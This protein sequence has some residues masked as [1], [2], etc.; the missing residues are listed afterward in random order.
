LATGVYTVT[1]TNANGCS[2]TA[3]TSTTINANPIAT[4]SSNIPCDGSTLNLTSGG[5]SSYNWSG[6]NGFSDTIQFPIM[7]NITPSAA[8]VYT[9]VVTNANGCSSSAQTTVTINANPIATASSNTPCEGAALNLTSGG[10]TAYSWS[11][12]NNFSNTTQ[13][14]A[15]TNVAISAGGTYTVTVTNAN[16][17][18]STAQTTATV[19]ANPTATASSNTPCVGATLNLTSGGGSGYSWSGP[20]S[21]SST[22]QNPTIANAAISA[23][24]SYTVTVTDA[25]GCSD[26]KNINV[27]IHSL[28]LITLSI[29]NN[30][31]CLTANPATL[32]GTPAGGSF[33][34]TGI[35]DSI[36]NP[37][38]AGIGTYNLI[39]YYTD[40]NSCSNSD[41]ISVSV[42][43]VPAVSLQSDPL[44]L[45]PI[46]TG[47]TV[48]ITAA[49]TNYSNYN[50]YIGS[51]SVQSGSSNTYQ[52]V[53]FL[54]G[55][56]VIVIATEDGC[57]ASDTLVLDINPLP[58][59]F[60]PNGS[61]EKNN[62][63][64][65]G[66]DLQIINR[67]GQQLYSGKDGWDGTYNGQTVSPGTY[68]YIIKLTDLN[69]NEKTIKGAVTV[70]AKK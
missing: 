50:F 30:T 10:G 14:P 63:F 37:S 15:I 23:G 28:P 13:N 11:G 69:K 21:F 20:N 58:N 19:N 31:Y 40:A 60:I 18:S 5:G 7:P 49:P 8:G 61:D 9:V 70:V 35:T 67:W 45:T 68:Y 53:T 34:G 56:H 12:P 32:T 44:V 47:E 2:S 25:K 64:L 26:T 27:I 39:Y 46:Y 57:T 51:N 17:C 62:L 52:S 6:P 22:T 36:F 59:A 41:T 48:T 1:V 55:D 3:Q 66:I 54:N 24:G 4:A 43:A 65:K 33:S 38:Q 16:G 42:H 29:P